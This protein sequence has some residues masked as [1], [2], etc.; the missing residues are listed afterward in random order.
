MKKYL[1]LFILSLNLYGNYC[2][3]NY[4]GK[5]YRAF[6]NEDSIYTIIELNNYKRILLNRYTQKYIKVRG[7]TD[8]EID[9]FNCSPVYSKCK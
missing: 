6:E 4:N 1:L 5:N 7:M 9:N 3:I 8:E 2:V